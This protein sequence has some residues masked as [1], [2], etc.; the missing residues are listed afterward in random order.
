VT[1]TGT[2]TSVD[3]EVN[4]GIYC[5]DVDPGRAGC[6]EAG[7][8]FWFW[9]TAGADRRKAQAKIAANR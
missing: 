4:C 7:A 2:M 8:A 3:V 5:C 1:V 9:G 6:W